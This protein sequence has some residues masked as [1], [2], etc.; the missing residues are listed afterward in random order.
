MRQILIATISNIFAIALLAGCSTANPSA[1]TKNYQVEILELTEPVYEVIRTENIDQQN[2]NGTGDVDN[3]I[4]RTMGINHSIEVGLGLTVDV[5][6]DL[7]LFGTGIDLGEAISSELGYQYGITESMARSITVRAAPKSHIVHTIKLSE[8]WEAGTARITANGQSMDIPFRFRTNFSIDL[9][10][11]MPIDCETGQAAAPLPLNQPTTL[12]QTSTQTPKADSSIEANTFET[13]LA[14]AQVTFEDKFDNTLFPGWLMWGGDSSTLYAQNGTAF[15]LSGAQLHRNHGLGE[16][17]ACLFTLNFSSDGGFMLAGTP[18]SYGP[19]W[20][21][22]GLINNPDLQSGGRMQDYF[23]EG[24][25]E[26]SINIYK[27]FSLQG[28]ADILYNVLLWVKGPAS[29][30]V[31]VWEKDNPNVFGEKNFQM[32]D[33]ENWAGRKWHC[34]LLVDSGMVQVSDYSEIILPAP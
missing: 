16:N 25:G 17:E 12:P 6:G 18:E 31:R 21:A 4:E 29:F 26:S 5:N 10:D 22:W 24:I 28:Q 15:F 3:V 2:C 7:K 19:D 20:R 11:S 30:T 14:S 34:N 33:S 9:L 13:I 1:D 23:Q 27:P 8:V 32:T